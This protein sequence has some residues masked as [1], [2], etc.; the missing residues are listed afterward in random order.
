MAQKK[1][2]IDKANKLISEAERIKE[3]DPNKSIDLIKEAIKIRPDYLLYDYFLLVR[4]LTKLENFG[5]RSLVE[6]REKLS[7]MQFELGTE[8]NTEVFEMEK[9][10]RSASLIE[11]E[12]DE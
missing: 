1:E 7:E 5:K 4:Y 11:D 6:I 9:E 2:L 3:E 8:L 10:I 12:V